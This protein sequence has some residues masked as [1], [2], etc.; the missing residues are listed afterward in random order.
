LL[1]AFIAG[2]AQRPEQAARQSRW[3]AVAF[4]GALWLLSVLLLWPVLGT[5]YVGLPLL[6]AT[7]ANMFGLLV[8]YASYGVSLI[9]LFG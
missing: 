3:F 5:S 1:Y 4:V 9:I 2:R 7:L 8:A 6:K